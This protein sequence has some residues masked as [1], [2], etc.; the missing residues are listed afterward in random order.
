MSNKKITV[1]RRNNIKKIDNNAVGL[2]LKAL[3]KPLANKSKRPPSKRNAQGSIARAISQGGYAQN[4]MVSAP[5]AF[6]SKTKVSKASFGGGKTIIKHSEYV[7]DIDGSTGFATPLT[8][9]CNP[10]LSASFPWLS[11]IAN[12]YEKFCIKQIQYRYAPEAPTTVTGAVFLS[13]EYNPQDVAPV[14]KQETFQNEDT[15]RTVPWEPVVCKIPTKYLKV[16]NDYFVR[17]GN[18]PA[19]Q[20]LKTY[21]PLVLYVCTQGQAN[22][23]LLGEIW[24]DYQIELINPQGN[25]NPVSGSGISTSG[26][27]A[28]HIFAGLTGYGYLTLGVTTTTNVLTLSPLVIG[29]EYVCTV[30]IIGATLL[31][32]APAVTTGGTQLSNEASMVNAAGTV[33]SCS[34]SFTATAQTATLTFTSTGTTY[35]NA[36]VWVSSIP[37]GGF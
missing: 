21:D 6:G 22:A 7:A 36:L 26:L 4:A 2:L 5:A 8:L 19:N 10:G 34:I 30:I 16:Y 35:S 20:D 31:T 1:K 11:Q 37:P 3:K 9:N 27:A 24:V 17:P 23:N 25:L 12:A 33:M 13:P 14:S 32:L 18:L 29:A 28:A 15:V